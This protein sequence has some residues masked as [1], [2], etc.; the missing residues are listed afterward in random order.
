MY[1]GVRLSGDELLEA[2]Q[3]KLHS[4]AEQERTAP[5]HKVKNPK[6]KQSAIDQEDIGMCISK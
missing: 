2:I 6:R 3:K 1:K 4:E 5:H